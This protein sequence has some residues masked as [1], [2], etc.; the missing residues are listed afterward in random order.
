METAQ[1]SGQTYRP[2]SLCIHAVSGVSLC[3]KWTRSSG[4]RTGVR[5][6][7]SPT[8]R[9]S[10]LRLTY[11]PG[12]KSRNATP[13]RL[14]CGS[15]FA[16]A[17]LVA[18]L[19]T[20]LYGVQGCGWLARARDTAR[21]NGRCSGAAAIRMPTH[22]SSAQSVACSRHVAE[23][24]SPCPGWPASDHVARK[25]TCAGDGAI[26]HWHRVRTVRVNAPP[27]LPPPPPPPPHNTPDCRNRF[28]CSVGR[29]DHVY[30]AR[31]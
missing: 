22:G 16:I 13:I 14:L 21:A 25:C 29:P 5:A 15:P 12:C 28:H 30:L 27:S 18:C 11:L 26:V 9:S 3:L 23:R 31:K 20:E 1:M 7:L 6:R 8:S 2:V 10:A 17:L 4:C 19:L 24:G